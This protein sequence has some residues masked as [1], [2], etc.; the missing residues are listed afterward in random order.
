MGYTK[1]LHEIS[2]GCFAYLQ[3]D[4]GWGWS[5]AGLLVGDGQSLLVDTLF[6]LKLTGE[7]LGAMRPHTRNAP[8]ATLVNTH[9]NGDHCYGNELVVGAEIIATEHAAREMTE[10]PPAMLAAMNRAP[11]E[12]GDMFR[13]FFGAFDFEGIESVLPTR[14]F[15]GSLSLEVGG[16]TVQL[17][18][19]GPAHTFGDAI[20]YSPSDR[21]V[22]TG[23]ILFNGGMPIV[24]AGPLSNWVAACDRILGLDID[25]VIPGHGPLTDKSGVV[26]MRD[27]LVRTDAEAR[28]CH[29]EG[30]DPWQAAQEIYRSSRADMSERGRVAVN[31]EAVWR[32]LDPAHRSPDLAELFK[33]MV[34]LEA[35]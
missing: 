4:G 29:A 21:A 5:N 3:P 31:V 15:T 17:V 8:I 10:V 6:D 32:E 34:T 22:Y 23:D 13:S 27:E 1:G 30:M 12:V 35:S 9:A 18:E 2:D 11:G 20:V 7:M 26:A 25:H 19:V 24:W 14:T 16:R 28:R 33:R